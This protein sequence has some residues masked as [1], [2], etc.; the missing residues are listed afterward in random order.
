MPS[1][2]SSQQP[3]SWIFVCFIYLTLKKGVEGKGR[4]GEEE[5]L[6]RRKGKAEGNGSCAGRG[7]ERAQPGTSPRG[8]GWGGVEPAG[9]V[10]LL[11]GLALERDESCF[12][13]EGCGS[14]LGS[15]VAHCILPRSPPAPAP[16]HA[17]RRLSE[18][19]PPARIGTGAESGAKC[20]GGFSFLRH[21][22]Q[23]LWAPGE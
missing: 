11:L 13:K 12:E 23:A 18:G 19:A 6:G 14:L 7:M 8:W 1:P 21:L 17:G 3:V 10:V 15:A 20:K 4:R 22:G 9:T 16:M 2:F 5:E